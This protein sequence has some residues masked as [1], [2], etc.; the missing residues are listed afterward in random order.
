VTADIKTGTVLLFSPLSWRS[1][2]SKDF[3][4]AMSE[5]QNEQ[6]PIQLPLRFS[7][8]KFLNVP[9][10]YF[11]LMYFRLEY[12]LRQKLFGSGSFIVFSNAR[13]GKYSMSVEI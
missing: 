8:L 2:G 6:N 10:W 9:L 12:H 1:N 4:I 3:I 7:K 11:E 13:L 5:R